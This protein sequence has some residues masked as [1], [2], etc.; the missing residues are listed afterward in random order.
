MATSA[1]D[2]SGEPAWQSRLDR[3]ELLRRGGLAAASLTAGLFWLSCG[4]DGDKKTGG[5][6]GKV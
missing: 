4:G 6:T 3:R 1:R 2:H 5:S